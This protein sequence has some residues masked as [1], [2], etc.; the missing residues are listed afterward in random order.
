[1]ISV[2][3]S[4]FFIFTFVVCLANSSKSNNRQIDSFDSY[5][6][7]V[8]TLSTAGATT[9]ITI[10]PGDILEGKHLCKLLCRES[11]IFPITLRGGA[12]KDED[13]HKINVHLTFLYASV[14]NAESLL[15]ACNSEATAPC[16][17]KVAALAKS[18][19]GKWI[20]IIIGVVFCL[21]VVVGV[22]VIVMKKKGDF[23]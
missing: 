21:L 20:W 22:I 1:M 8:A 13:K 11:Q 15:N 23:L 14:A 5:P 9:L 6:K 7:H 2:Y 4:F 10:T 12:I 17:K 19:D 3:A 16:M 18:D